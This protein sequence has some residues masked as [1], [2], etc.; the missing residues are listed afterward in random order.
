MKKLIESANVNSML[1]IMDLQDNRFS[2]DKLK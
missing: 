1:R 2:T